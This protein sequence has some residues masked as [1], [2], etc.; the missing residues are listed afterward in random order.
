MLLL[1]FVPKFESMFSFYYS[2]I[3]KK[4]SL[5]FEMF[6]CFM[7]F[8]LNE[9]LDLFNDIFLFLSYIFYLYD[10]ALIY[11]FYL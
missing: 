2:L 10:K 7:V 3:F 4:S 5:I 9:S 6:L 11:G 8:L 1:L